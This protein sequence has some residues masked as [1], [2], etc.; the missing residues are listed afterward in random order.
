MV[1]GGVSIRTGDYLMADRDGALVIP[2]EI[3]EEVTSGVEEI[4]RTE[5]KVRTAILQGTDPV[6]AYLRFRKF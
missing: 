4:L 5:N 6:D 1:I 2:G 3:I